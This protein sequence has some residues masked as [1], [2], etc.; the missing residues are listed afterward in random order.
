ML[1]CSDQAK[2][3]LSKAGWYPGR[4]VDIAVYRDIIL[5][6]SYKIFRIV[7]KFLHEFGGLAV[8]FKLRNGSQTTL[9]FN[10]TQAVE[11][12]D[13][14]WAQN[15]YYTRLGNKDV[16]VVGQAYTDHLTLMMDEAGAVYGGFDDYL[17]F[18]ANSGEEAIEAI[19]SNAIF[20]AIP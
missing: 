19:C 1:E 6:D 16:C 18:I 14:I 11:E 3:L 8:E 12:V 7:E 9:H 5:K 20:D 4:Y 10:V 17:C 2:K 13:P 15:D